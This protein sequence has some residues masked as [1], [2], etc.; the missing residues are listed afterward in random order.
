MP[1]LDVQAT[2]P[3]GNPPALWQTTLRV[4]VFPQLSTQSLI[5]LA[6]AL[7]ADSPRILQGGTTRPPPLA[8]MADWPCEAA[9]PL[10][11]CGLSEGLET[12]GEIEE[13][14]ARLCFECDN[15]MGEP[16]AVRWFLNWADETPRDVMRPA[17]LT[18]VNAELSRRGVKGAEAA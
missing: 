15:L 14:F 11:F 13:F 10:G 3:P 6:S 8:C 18:E 5:A 7:R 9:C 12:V 17:L 4:G 1:E 2:A 16:S